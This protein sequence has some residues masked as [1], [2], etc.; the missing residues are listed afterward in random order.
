MSKPRQGAVA[1][2]P[3]IATRAE[4]DRRIAGRPKPTTERRLTIDGWQQQEV[5]RQVNAFAESRIK[6]LESRLN[7]ARQGL[8][9]DV[10]TAAVRGR[11]RA[12][13]ERNR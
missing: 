2:V 11:A 10:R 13:F 3:P 4:L 8:E 7:R 12:D 9:R 6:A 1:E 5:H